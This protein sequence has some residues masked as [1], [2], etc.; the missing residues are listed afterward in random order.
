MSYILYKTNGTVLTTI[1]DGS[2]DQTST[3]LTLVGKNYS[4]YGQIINQ[5]LIKLTENFAYNVQP[6]NAMTG[7]LWYD[8]ANKAL[9][10]YNGSRFRQL[11]VIDSNSNGPTDAVQGDL[12]FN[13]TDQKLYYNNGTTWLVIGPQF[14]GLGSNNLITPQLVYDTGTAP[15]FILEAQMQLGS[16]TTSTEVAAVFSVDEFTLNGSSSVNGFNIIKSGIT[17]YGADPITG[18]SASGPTGSTIMWGT[19]ADS[20]RL[21]GVSANQYVTV[22]APQFNSQLSV[23]SK[24]G[25]NIN[26]G[27]LILQSI[28]VGGYTQAVISANNS[29]GNNGTK[30]QVNVNLGNTTTNIVSFGA[31]GGGTPAILPTTAVGVT[32]DI[33]TI[34]APFGQVYSNKV[35]ANMFTITNQYSSNAARDAAIPAPSIGTIVLVGTTFQGNVDGTIT[36]WVNLN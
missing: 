36:G 19:S 20:L 29:N 16:V 3:P 5:D 18:V 24:L 25:V 2:I 7:Q 31:S 28:L 26:T 21:G 32:T 10:A 34:T 9:K 33:G 15:H 8:S 14:T 6:A 27:D 12:W 13:E 23:N 11:A 1:L 30:L 35:N 17:L 22:N 4:G